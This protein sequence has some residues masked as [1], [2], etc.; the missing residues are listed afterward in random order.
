[1]DDP[2]VREA[3]ALAKAGQRGAARRLILNHLRHHRA[4]AES[5]V[6]LAQLVDDHREA[7]YCMRQAVR[8]RPGDEKTR[9]LLERME[10][11]DRLFRPEAAP[12]PGPRPT[13]R[14]VPA[15]APS[16]RPTLPA[17]ARETQRKRPPLNLPLAI[18]VPLVAAL[19]LIAVFGPWIA[20]QDP[21]GRTTLAEVTPGEFRSPPF[22][23]G[24]VPGF[25]LGADHIGRDI[26][27]RLLWAA[28]PTFVLAVGVA[29]ARMLIG[30]GL[31]FLEGWYSGRFGDF[32][33][34]VINVAAALPVLLVAI[35]VLL[36][37][38][39]A[40]VGESTSAFLVALSVTGWASAARLAAE[41]VRLIRTEPYI[42]AARA[43]G[44]SDGR[45]MFKHVLPQVVTLLPVVFSFEMSAT[46]LL[47]AE[48]GFLGFFIGGSEM[49]AL[50]NAQDPGFTLV[51]VPGMPELGQMLSMGWDN[52]F[53]EP[54]LSVYV[55]AA[56]FVSVLAF[57]LLGEGLKRRA[58]RLSAYPPPLATMTRR[59]LARA[60]T[61]I[62][63]KTIWG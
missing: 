4:S 53:L 43:L 26:L 58:A 51:P 49:F 35:V 45:I 36:L 57:M 40:G 24:E 19:M 38:R 12:R 1:M 31:G 10:R 63:G 54:W 39:L 6:V 9:A 29:A 62:P 21:V 8:L 7:V 27:S 59:V 48:L 15:A 61:L 50:P 2:A 22:R 25:P 14:H 52:F 20:P 37:L 16:A 56:F 23:P 34:S 18:G 30:G 41:R 47:T 33:A 60:G 28:Q 11:G 5:W 55:G 3:I 44:S 13:P 17:P 46:L 32:L 42:E